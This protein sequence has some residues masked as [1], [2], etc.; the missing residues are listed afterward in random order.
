MSYYLLWNT[1]IPYYCTGILITFIK[2]FKSIAEAME[3]SDATAEEAKQSK[4]ESEIVTKEDENRKIAAE[5]LKRLTN[6]K[7]S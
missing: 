6:L 3:T 4:E 7:I 2:F 1:V 5:A